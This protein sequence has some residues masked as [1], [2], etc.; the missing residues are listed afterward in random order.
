M[1]RPQDAGRQ[2]AR[3]PA[4]VKRREINLAR[5][6][7]RCTRKEPGCLTLCPAERG[8]PKTGE[9][10]ESAGVCGEDGGMCGELLARFRVQEASEAGR[11]VRGRGRGGSGSILA[12]R[13][14]SAPKLRVFLGQIRPTQ[15]LSVRCRRRPDP[16]DERRSR[17]LRRCFRAVMKRFEAPAVRKESSCCNHNKEIRTEEGRTDGLVT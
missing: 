12:I 6:R 15:L 17:R 7:R 11:F 2:V 3:F 10:R 8:A 14:S 4:H 9:S 1:I 16:R 13:P 5:S